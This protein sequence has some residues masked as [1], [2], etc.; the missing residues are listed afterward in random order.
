MDNVQLN[1]ARYY[2]RKI[3]ALKIYTSEIVTLVIKEQ[4]R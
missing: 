3:N 2:N 1:Y 4:K